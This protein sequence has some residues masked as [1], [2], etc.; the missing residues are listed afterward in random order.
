MPR[1]K[2]RV[3]VVGGGFDT[4]SATEDIEELRYAE[5]VVIDRL[6]GGFEDLAPSEG[7]DLFTKK[8]CQYHSRIYR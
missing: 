2:K 5:P 1:I 6:L 3:N 4:S 8:I 7:A